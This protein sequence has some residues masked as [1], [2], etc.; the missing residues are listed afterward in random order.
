MTSRLYVAT[1]TSTRFSN[2]KKPESAEA[3]QVNNRTSIDSDHIRAAFSISKR[4]TR[5][6]T[7]RNQQHHYVPDRSHLQYNDERRAHQHTSPSGC[8]MR[9]CRRH[10]CSTNGIHSTTMSVVPTSTPVLL[11]ASYTSSGFI[12]PKRCRPSAQSMSFSSTCQLYLEALYARSSMNRPIDR[13]RTATVRSVLISSELRLDGLYTSDSIMTDPSHHSA[14]T[15]LFC[16]SMR[17][18]ST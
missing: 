17:E 15:S 2:S 14:S 4:V 16:L 1:G 3:K 13:H 7:T 9:E 5:R 12:G 6:C 8:I 18:P 10:P 11:A